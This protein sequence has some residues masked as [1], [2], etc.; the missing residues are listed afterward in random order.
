MVWPLELVPSGKMTTSVPAARAV[1]ISRFTAPTCVRRSRST[2][3]VPAMAANQPNS[4]QRRTSALDTKTAGVVFKPLI[5]WEGIERAADNDSV[6]AGLLRRFHYLNYGL[7]VILVLIGL[8]MLS[9]AWVTVPAL[10]A[11][12]AVVA[13]LGLAM[14]A[15]WFR[16][17][18]A[19][20]LA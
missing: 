11:L 12:A 5:G 20:P 10:A 6:L 4:G 13:V 7:A 2:N 18:P 15:S 17:R 19:G 16:P 9:S 3:T 8:K 14:L 1:S